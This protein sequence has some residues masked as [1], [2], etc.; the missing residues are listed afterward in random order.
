[1]SSN[2]PGERMMRIETM[3][4]NINEKL[5]ALTEKVDR[6][7]AAAIKD[8]ADLRDLK[9]RGAGILIGVG[10]ISIFIGSKIEAIAMAAVSLFK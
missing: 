2:T 6:V 8:A 1:M 9:N 3:F 7:E 4:E 10:A 5:S